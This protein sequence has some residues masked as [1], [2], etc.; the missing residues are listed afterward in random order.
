MT[1]KKTTRQG[2]RER[3]LEVLVHIQNH[4]D[5]DLSLEALADLACFSP[6]HFH[7]VFRGMVGESVA[8][9]VRRLR[10]DRAAYLLRI[11]RNR[12][13]TDVAFEAGYE[14]V[15]S[16]TRA[17]RSAHGLSPSVYR[18]RF[19]AGK[20]TFDDQNG[21]VVLPDRS[22][23]KTMEIKIVKRQPTKVA[24][25]RHVGPY[26]QCGRAWEKLCAWAG[27]KELL[28]PQTSYIGLCHD[29]PEITPPDKIRYDACLT[30]DRP[31][32]PEGEVGLQEISGG[33]YAF[34]LHKGPYDRLK[35]VYAELA[36][37]WLPETG[38]EIASKPSLEICLNDPNETPS[39]ELLTEV[40]M[41]LED[42]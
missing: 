4:L 38:R 11:N 39:E 28:G 34:T 12:P 18:R 21:P 37:V 16:F 1:V 15:E 29:D 20:S 26:E 17:F 41:P 30:I 7:R 31:L 36:G 5:E 8:G 10:L 6:Y 19:P 22:G 40:Y 13:V 42:E 35:D 14:T 9:Y 33:D 27:P 3:M 23:E 2:Y 24:F 32:E 25:V